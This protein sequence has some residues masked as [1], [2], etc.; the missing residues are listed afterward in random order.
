MLGKY[1]KLRDADTKLLTQPPETPPPPP[2]DPKIAADAQKVQ[3]QAQTAMQL[4]QMEM[5]DSA[6]KFQA[7]QQT[8]MQIDQNRQEWEERQKQME[9]QQMAQLEQVKAAFNEAQSTKQFQFDQ[10]RAELEA[11][12]RITIAQIGAAVA[13][14]KQ[15]ADSQRHDDGI[16]M[17]G[18]NTAREDA[19]EAREAAKGTE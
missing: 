6:H 11:Q 18:F 5:Q 8:Q 17:N 12:T 7:E 13:V 9:L 10:W 2:Q 3:F 4:K 15:E 1:G 19:A 16:V 14:K